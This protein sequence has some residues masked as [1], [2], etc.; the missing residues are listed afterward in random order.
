MSNIIIIAKLAVFASLIASI[1]AVVPRPKASVDDS[2]YNIFSIDG[3]GI[4][5]LIPA[6]VIDYMEK[7][8]YEYAETKGYISS[9]K[10]PLY[11][12]VIGEKRVHM[13]ELFDFMAGTST[14]SIISTGLSIPFEEK[15]GS[16][17]KETPK[18]GAT[19]MISIYSTQGD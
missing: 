2:Y 16:Y 19:E 11:S 1:S 12:E 6:V 7:Y 4:R 15:D 17:S 14:G 10:I 3:G 13:K 9:G 18:F 8:A 5:G